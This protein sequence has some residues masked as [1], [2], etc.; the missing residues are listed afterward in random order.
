MVAFGPEDLTS[1][2]FDE[3]GV[4]AQSIAPALQAALEELVDG[5]LP[6]LHQ[7]VPVAGTDLGGGVG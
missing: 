6:G 7:G 4:D 1:G 2:R 5:Q 3:L